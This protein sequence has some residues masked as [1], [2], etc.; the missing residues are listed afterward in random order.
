MRRAWIHGAMGAAAL[1]AAPAAPAVEPLVAASSEEH[2]WYIA[3]TGP[4]TFEV[5]HLAADA[6][7]A[8]FDRGLRLPRPPVALA[9]WDRQLWLAFDE[10]GRLDV[11]TVEVTRAPALGGWIHD[12]VDRLRP[13]TAIEEPVSLGGFTG[14]GQGPAALV[15][16]SG[17]DVRLVQL[18][19]G[20]WQPLPVPRDLPSGARLLAAGGS[21]GQVLLLVAPGGA[22][23]RRGPDGAWTAGEAAIAPESL[24][25][26]CRVGSAVALLLEGP[27]A[28]SNR[29]AWLRPAGVLPLVDFDVPAGHRCAL[30]GLGGGLVLIDQDAG[31]DG[32][33]RRIDI[34]T[35]ESG[36]RRRLSPSALLTGRSLHWPV[37]AI[38][39]VAGLMVVLALGPRPAGALALPPELVPL[40]I[41]GRLAA[42]L[43]DWAIAGTAVIILLRC[44]PSDLVRSPLLTADLAGAVPFLLAAGLTVALGAAGELAS[45]RSPGKALLGARVV[46]ASG[47]RPS[48]LAILA[49]NLIKAIVLLVPVLAI[50]ALLSP[51]VQGLGDLVARTVVVRR[52]DPPPKDR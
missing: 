8:H 6:R 45:G 26:S 47:A 33:T 44:A 14:T 36:P 10:E 24:R 34:H 3:E 50:V 11:F 9:A 30:V 49:R 52:A 43:V 35:G 25:A 27:R 23:H 20:Q 16:D 22:V 29:I 39:L 2:A 1:C 51:N 28:G 13:V 31:G 48:A 4:A 17:G 42:L 15:T 40:G 12:P 38:A 18:R 7:G 21:E 41:G 5:R 32:W 46:S 37:L 19:G